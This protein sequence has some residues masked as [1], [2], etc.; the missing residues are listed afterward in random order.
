[1]KK[2]KIMMQLPVFNFTVYLVQPKGL[3]DDQ[4]LKISTFNPITK[5]GTVVSGYDVNL[6]EVEAVSFLRECKK[7]TGRQAAVIH[8]ASNPNDTE[9]YVE[10]QFL[11]AQNKIMHINEQPKILLYDPSFTV[12]SFMNKIRYSRY[13]KAN[14]LDITTNIDIAKIKVLGSLETMKERSIVSN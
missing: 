3:Q 5:A 13:L 2:E 9:A 4:K 14:F 1:M 7:L 12:D 6:V 8:T 10:N 11:Q